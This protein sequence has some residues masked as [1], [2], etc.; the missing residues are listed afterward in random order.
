MKC[1]RN[2]EVPL[3]VVVVQGW[4][5]IVDSGKLQNRKDD[6]R[7]LHWDLLLAFATFKKILKSQNQHYIIFTVL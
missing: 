2:L 7:Y 5:W 3:G 4:V 1:G 6:Y